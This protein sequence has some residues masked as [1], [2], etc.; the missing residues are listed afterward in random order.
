[1]AIDRSTKGAEQLCR[2]WHRARFHGHYTTP[3]CCTGNSLNRLWDL[4]VTRD[5][6]K[7]GKMRDFYVCLGLGAVLGLLGLLYILAPVTLSETV[8]GE[9]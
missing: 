6:L 5:H 1:M 7:G 8:W 9:F 2:A 4:L 3:R